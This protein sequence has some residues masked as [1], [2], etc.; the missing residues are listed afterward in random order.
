MNEKQQK[1]IEMYQQGKPIKEIE[2]E[3]DI[4]AMSIYNILDN[5]RIEKNREPGNK[6]STEIIKKILYKYFQEFK[7]QEEV[8]EELDVSIVT[9]R[10][11]ITRYKKDI[12]LNGLK[13][14]N[15]E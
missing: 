14:V 10:N 9:V 1:I 2:H 11:Y 12:M 15:I 5:N 13:N 4:S 3:C 6:L 8:S 7:T